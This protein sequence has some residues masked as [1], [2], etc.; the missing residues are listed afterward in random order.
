MSTSV[1]IVDYGCG[2]LFSLAR[3]LE[4]VGASVDVCS[5]ESRVSTADRL[6]LPGVGAFGKAMN[7]LDA[8]GMKNAVLEFVTTGRP[9]LGICVGMQ[10]L[11]NASTE[12]G[13]HDGLGLI[14]GKV[15]KIPNVAD[16]GSR[17]PVPHIGW[18]VLHGAE[19]T[20]S[21]S[22]LEDTPEESAVYFVH[23][24]HGECED[25]GNCIA[26]TSYGGNTLTAAVRADNITGVQFHPEKSGPTGLAILNRFMSG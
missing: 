12:F 20:W 23:S 25:P 5:D 24:F 13:S 26:T 11:F 7:E 3:A 22:I 10:M 1:T 18:N 6:V 21:G 19:A 17:L 2:N 4:A 16:D 14:P 15:E 9:F 8:R